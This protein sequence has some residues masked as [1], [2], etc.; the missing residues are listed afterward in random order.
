MK[1]K[2]YRFLY[3]NDALIEW[4]RN[5]KDPKCTA[6]IKSLRTYFNHYY[7]VNWITLAFL[8]DNSPEGFSFWDK[9]NDKWRKEINK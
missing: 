7:D 4:K 6:S 3:E 9:L 1:K 8:W 5:I 2:F